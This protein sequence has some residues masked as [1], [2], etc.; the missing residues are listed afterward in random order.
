MKISKR[1]KIM[2]GLCV[3]GI[4]VVAFDRLTDKSPVFQPRAAAAAAISP[5]SPAN[6]GP[7][8]TAAPA[9][10]PASDEPPG[11]AIARRLRTLTGEQ[12]PAPAEMRD[13]FRP[14]APWVI[15][16]AAK[17]AVEAVV[18]KSKAEDFVKQH[19]LQAILSAG[20]EWRAVID[21]KTLKVG[22]SCWAGF[23]VTSITSQKVVLTSAD[24]VTITL[25]L[26][27]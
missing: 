9:A 27:T 1:Q 22:D 6:A 16:V 21:F 19:K 13:I 5:G 3:L 26:W 20:G 18:D 8:S 12:E 7:G 2:V 24:S 10:A 17:P 23:R 14:G 25:E 15:E 11:T 4:A